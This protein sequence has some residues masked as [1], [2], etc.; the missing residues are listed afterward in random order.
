[1]ISRLIISLKKAASGE[2]GWTSME[3]ATV[4]RVEG[5][6]FERSENSIRTQPSL[7]GGRAGNGF[8][9]LGRRDLSEAVS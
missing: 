7:G 1:M 3:M 8:R 5:L 6:H 9:A 4:R 2:D